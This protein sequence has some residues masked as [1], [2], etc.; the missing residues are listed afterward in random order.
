M[1]DP[2]TAAELVAML[3]AELAFERRDFAETVKAEERK[4][5]DALCAL[6]KREQRLACG[7]PAEPDDFDD[8]PPKPR[9]KR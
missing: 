8:A 6:F 9:A 5:A 4:A 3:R 2:Q 7:L 1:S